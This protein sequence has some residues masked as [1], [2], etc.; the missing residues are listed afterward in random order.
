[1]SDDHQGDAHRAPTSLASTD[2]MVTDIPPAMCGLHDPLYIIDLRS[3]R[4]FPLR[5]KRNK[6]AYCLPI[7]A[8]RRALAITATQPKRMIRLSLMA[9]RGDPDPLST[10]RTRIKRLRQ[11]LKRLGIPMGEWCWTL[12][13]NPAGTGYHAHATQHGPFIHQ[14]ALQE[15][16][17]RAGAGIPY[18]NQ[19]KSKPSVTARYGLK[20]F[21]AAG[22]GLKTY[23]QT[24]SAA[25]ALELNHGRLE[26]H[27]PGFFVIDGCKVSPREAESIAVKQLYGEG[28]DSYIIVPR[29]VA[30]YYMSPTGRHLMPRPVTRSGDHSQATA[31]G[32][33]VR[34]SVAVPTT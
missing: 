19:I 3:Q 21:G 33:A 14:A 2:G 34:E 17:A 7:N 27:T 8:R 4:A 25:M 32:Q 9:D 1:M 6:C 5:C 22:Y 24:E 11:A 23:R 13:V 30:R 10:A 15:A 12:E 16:C 26:H 18:I 20:G 31:G 28:F 29:D